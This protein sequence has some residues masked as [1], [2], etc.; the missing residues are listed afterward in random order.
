MWASDRPSPTQLE[1]PVQVCVGESPTQ[2]GK[3]K[4]TRP[5]IRCCVCYKVMAK[6][7]SNMPTQRADDDIFQLVRKNAAE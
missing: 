4:R 6:R 2:T 3:L 5:R 7:V 1:H